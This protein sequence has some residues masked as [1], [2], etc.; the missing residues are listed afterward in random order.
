MKKVG[1][2]KIAASSLILGAAI[3]PV[4]ASSYGHETSG[5]QKAAAQAAQ[6]L[7]YAPG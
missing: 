6:Q 3:T 2:L 1:M 5:P 4:S 7:S